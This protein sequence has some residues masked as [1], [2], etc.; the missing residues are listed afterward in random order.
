MLTVMIPHWHQ[1]KLLIPI[2]SV[3]LCFGG[4]LTAVS[5][6]Q[7]RFWFTY[8]GFVVFAMGYRIAQ[9]GANEREWTMLDNETSSNQMIK[10][11]GRKYGL[12]GVGTAIAAYGG[13]VGAQSVET[14]D[15]WKMVLSGV[16]MS[17]GYII[18]HIGLNN[19]YV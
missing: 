16:C 19:S 14:L 3:A 10:R 8:L 13:M 4:S 7:N 11:L 6:F 9:I 5:A 2:G 18:G 17:G 1:R 12:L 15:F